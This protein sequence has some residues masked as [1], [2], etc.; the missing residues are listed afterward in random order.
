M[1]GRAFL[2]DPQGGG[3]ASG[4]KKGC[5]PEKGCWLAPPPSPSTIDKI[6]LSKRV[7]WGEGGPGAGKKATGWLPAPGWAGSPPPGGGVGSTLRKALMGDADSPRPLP[8]SLAWAI[9]RLK[10]GAK[11]TWYLGQL[12]T[13]DRVIT[14]RDNH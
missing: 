6:S 4:G 13:F 2:N 8:A 9:C 11:K 3:P 1:G 14:S 5:W 10:G 12:G 7:W